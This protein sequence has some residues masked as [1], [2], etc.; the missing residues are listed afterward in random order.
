MYLD[1]KISEFCIDDSDIS[2]E[3]ADKL[4]MHICILQDIRNQLGRPV[5]ISKNSGYRPYDYERA[6]GRSGNSEH[7]FVGNGAV[8]VTCDPYYME[9]LLFLLHESKYNRVCY[10]SNQKFIHCD[11]KDNEKKKYICDGVTG[12]VSA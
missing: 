10:Y 4:L 5:I 8:D 2:Q 9:D 12:W 11:F 6:K 7:C 1:F 3:V